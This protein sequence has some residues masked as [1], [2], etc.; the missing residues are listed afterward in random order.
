[1]R[2][3][4][5]DIGR[6]II[7]SLPHGAEQHLVV[8]GQ[9]LL[10]SLNANAPTLGADDGA[11]FTR[12]GLN[13][14]DPAQQGE[15]DFALVDLAPHATLT[16]LKRAFSS[17]NYT[18][19]GTAAPGYIASYGHVESTPL[20]LAGLLTLLGIGVLA[21]LLVTSVRA[22]HKELAVLKTLG[23]T[24][25][26]LLMMVVWHAVLLALIALTIGLTLGVVLGRVAWTHFALSL[27]LA[28]NL[29]TPSAQL[30]AIA[31]TGLAVAALI[32][33]IPA[34]N[35]TRIAPARALRA[36]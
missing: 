19:T 30:A 29:T 8:V 17:S 1:M 33:S 24:R 14:L 21:H 2:Q 3:L 15:I 20:V 9:T 18:V 36:E 22:R 27:G 5:T 25:G 34:R 4:H 10:P 13:R 11:A 12:V 35:A 28:T 32:A 23:C 16:D 7:A 26:Q 31:V 6:T